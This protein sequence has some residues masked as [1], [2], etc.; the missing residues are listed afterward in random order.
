MAKR[1]RLNFDT[2]A[3][4]DKLRGQF[5]GLDPNDP[6][7]DAKPN[8][9]RDYATGKYVVVNNYINAR[10]NSDQAHS[11]FLP[12]MHADDRAALVHRCLE[13]TEYWHAI[14][15]QRAKLP[16]EIG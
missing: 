1:S 15:I 9:E 3:L 10:Q 14:R 6:Y 4:Q 7:K 8:Y 11:G 16:V 2:K 5:T 13:P 12:R